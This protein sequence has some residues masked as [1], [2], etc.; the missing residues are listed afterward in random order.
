MYILYTSDI[1]EMTIALTYCDIQGSY[2][3]CV[4]IV[5]HVRISHI[6]ERLEKAL[7]IAKTFANSRHISITKGSIKSNPPIVKQYMV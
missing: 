1:S 7:G 4:I 6:Y 3:N 5:S 2:G